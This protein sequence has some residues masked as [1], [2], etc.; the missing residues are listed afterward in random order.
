MNSELFYLRKILPEIKEII[1]SRAIILKTILE[2]QPV[3]RRSLAK[4]LNLGERQIRNETNILANEELLKITG[5]GL[6]ITNDGKELL[7]KIEPLIRNI[8]NIDS[9][10]EVLE[11]NLNLKKVIIV[12]GEASENQVVKKE[13][14]KRTAE[15]LSRI[16][17]T[18][19]SI[20]VAGG[21]TL[22]EVAEHIHPQNRPDLMV[23]PA[24]GGLGEEVEIQANTIAAKIAKKMKAKYKLLH[25]PETINEKISQELL[26]TPSI[27][28]IVTQIKESE[29]LLLGL[30]SIREIAL[31]KQIEAN[32]LIHLEDNGAKG[33][34]LGYFFNEDGEV[35]YARSSIG[36]TLEDLQKKK[37]II[38]VAGSKKKADAIKAV[39]KKGFIDI[40]ITD[41]G[42]AE[43]IASTL[44]I[45]NN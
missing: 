41:E 34:A 30:S 7:E 28:E 8:V 25:L 10:E 18:Y 20:A 35:I 2:F 5:A 23:L 22:A 1:K 4:R 36:I 12:P 45:K 27:A 9:L 32:E 44:E 15:Y 11:E 24:R 38:A 31:R 40:L 19:E 3:G 21:T 37:L 13:L 16:E 26:E 14:G 17:F 33:E 6:E 29:I 43:K 42:A 39:A